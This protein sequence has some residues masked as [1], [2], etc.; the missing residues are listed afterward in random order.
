MDFFAGDGYTLDNIKKTDYIDCP[1][2]LLFSKRFV[3]K[4]GNILEKELQFF[5]CNL[6]C[7]NNNF[8]WYAAKIIRSI[9][10]VDKEASIYRT[11]TDGTRMLKLAKYRKDM[12]ESFFIAKDIEYVTDILVSELFKELCE[13]ND[14]HIKFEKPEIF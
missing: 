9:P 1:S 12:K 14:I 3:Q 8:E 11:L 7:Q 13:K 2:A 5:P 4:V 10:I 6:V